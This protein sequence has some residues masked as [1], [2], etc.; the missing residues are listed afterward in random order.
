MM[1]NDFDLLNFFQTAG[2]TYALM[3]VAL[4]LILN[5]GTRK[6]K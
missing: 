1:G 2:L 6:R 4:L 5:L 3:L